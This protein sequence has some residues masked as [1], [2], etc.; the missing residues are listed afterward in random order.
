MADLSINDLARMVGVPVERLLEQIKEAGLPQS[1]A[2]D[3]TYW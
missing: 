3:R 1:S 2:T